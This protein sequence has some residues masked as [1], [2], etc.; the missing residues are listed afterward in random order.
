MALMKSEVESGKAKPETLLNYAVKMSDSGMDYEE[1]AKKFRIGYCPTEWQL[2]FNHLK[3]KKYWDQDIEKAGLI[4]N[5]AS[6]SS[7][8]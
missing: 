8:N 4:T 1:T 7:R 6:K 3:S 5:A 2:L